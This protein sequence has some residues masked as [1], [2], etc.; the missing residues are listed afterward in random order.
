MGRRGAEIAQEDMVL[1]YEVAGHGEEPVRAMAGGRS[2]LPEEVSAWVLRKV[3]ADAERYLQESVERAVI[4][5]P[6]Y[7]NDAQRSATKKAGE[8]AGLRVERIINEPTAACLSYGLDKKLDARVAVYDLGGGTFDISILQVKQGVFQVLS[9]CG[10]TRL[11]GDDLDRR[12]VDFILEKIREEAGVDLSSNPVALSRIREEAERAKCQLS[13]EEEVDIRLPFLTPS[14]SFDYRMTRTEFEKKVEDILEKTRRPCLQALMDAKSAVEAIDEVILVG[15]S[16][17]IPWVRRLVEEIF[18][19]PPDT[20]VNPDEAVALGAAIQGGVLSG[21]I[22]NL[23]L[24]DVTP[25]SLGIETYG[26]FM[27]VIIPRNTTIPTRAGELFTTAVDNQKHVTIQVLQ[28]ERPMVSDN[29]SL[30][31]FILEDIE[32]APAGVSRIG[33]QFTIDADGILHVLARDT[34]TGKEKVVRMKS[35][36]DV[37]EEDVERMVRDS[38]EHAK[39]DEAKREFV[40][41][42]IEAEKTLSAAKKGMEGFGRRLTPEERTKVETAIQGLV[43]TLDGEDT[44]A[45]QEATRKLDLATQHLASLMLDEALKTAAEKESGRR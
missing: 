5:V 35:T 34:K 12:L 7:F 30:G 45:L 15:G 44:A 39:E 42:K 29:W 27:N 20:S 41:A 23:L 1:T 16:T 17:R 40:L 38:I 21:G 6:A 43:R 22:T 4:T 9:T 24:L 11:G 19:R 3:K 2:Y 25:L 18:K 32:P 26:G 28:G 31:K 33:V 14:Y 10:N 36:L 13:S 8:I 37:R